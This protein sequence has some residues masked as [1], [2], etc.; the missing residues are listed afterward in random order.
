LRSEPGPLVLN[1]LGDLER[2]RA[3]TDRF[4]VQAQFL[5]PEEDASPLDVALPLDVMHLLALGTAWRNGRLLHQVPAKI[6]R[7]RVDFAAHQDRIAQS[8][9]AL[10]PKW[11]YKLYGMANKGPCH[12]FVTDKGSELVIPLAEI[13]RTWYLFHPVMVRVIIGNG[14][15]APR[16]MSAKD[17]PWDRDET[18][19]TGDGAHVT[20]RT[21]IG[22]PTM[23]R[24][25]RLLFSEHARDESER[26]ATHL[27][28][29]GA[30]GRLDFGSRTLPPLDGTAEL[31]YRYVDLGRAP[32]DGPLRRLVLSVL[33]VAHPVP[34]NELSLLPMNDSRPGDGDHTLPMM[35]SWTRPGMIDEEEGVTLHGDG[36]DSDIEAIHT[37]LLPFED[38][39][40]AVPARMLERKPAE[41]RAGR[42]NNEP[43]AVRETG[44][45]QGGL[46]AEGVAPMAADE[47]VKLPT[48]EPIIVPLLR[49]RAVFDEVIIELQTQ[50][51]HWT[52]DYIGLAGT[53]NG[54]LEFQHEDRPGF[55]F[56]ILHIRRPGA[57]IYVLRA[58]HLEETDGKSHRILVCRQASHAAIP[59]HNFVQWLQGFPYAGGGS[60]WLDLTGDLRLVPKHLNHQLRDEPFIES[61][62]RARFAARITEAVVAMALG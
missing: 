16:T 18:R 43:V 46:N 53:T 56:L 6:G 50:L 41:Y 36:Y 7:A 12:L 28:V 29:H 24:L 35:H 42:H 40:Y 31:R 30:R 49:M 17:L 13:V 34:F 4:T 57:N 3:R 10:I 15:A 14:I 1:W 5:R 54:V 2:V 22:E 59:T 27:R 38:N 44:L 58:A 9:G 8:P 21:S 61:A 32:K 51:P 25:A 62:W 39:V 19:S 33:E 23:R 45:D 37:A 47:M 26:L 55:R 60:V 20:Y 11:A 52:A 48:R